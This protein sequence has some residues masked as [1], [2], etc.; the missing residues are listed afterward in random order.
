MIFVIFNVCRLKQMISQF[1]VDDDRIS[2][3]G[4][5][6]QVLI[7]VYHKSLGMQCIENYTTDLCE[8]C[9]LGQFFSLNLM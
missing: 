1:E 7:T 2:T 3:N 8:N 9:F 4:H 6:T 5:I